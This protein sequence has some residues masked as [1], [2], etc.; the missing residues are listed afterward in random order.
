[1]FEAMSK[2]EFG[3]Y[4]LS[5]MTKANRLPEGYAG[6]FA[7]ERSGNLF[8]AGPASNG[9]RVVRIVRSKVSDDCITVSEGNIR[10]P[11]VG[12]NGL[13]ALYVKAA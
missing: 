4:V 3:A 2:S 7:Y 11:E 12:S 10:R 6:P 9:E 1:M 13:Q 8:Y 5:K